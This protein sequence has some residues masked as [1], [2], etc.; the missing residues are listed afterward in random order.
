MR[1][2][3]GTVWAQGREGKQEQRRSRLY[4]GL[5]ITRGVNQA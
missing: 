4:H 3:A 1:G 5:T 2:G